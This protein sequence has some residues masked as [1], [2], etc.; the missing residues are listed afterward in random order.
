[1][2]VIK[3]NYFTK[4]ENIF[5]VIRFYFNARA[6]N[7]ANR[8]GAPITPPPAMKRWIK[9]I[10]N[11][12]CISRKPLYNSKVQ[13]ESIACACILTCFSRS[14]LYNSQGCCEFP[15]LFIIIRIRICFENK[16]NKI[17]Y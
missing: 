14:P 8:P 5:F 15:L 2:E 9:P 7:A 16:G 3:I 1:M 12:H 4:I 6:D 13:M 10:Y 17:N 11:S